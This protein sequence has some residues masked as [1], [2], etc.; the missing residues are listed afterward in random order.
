MI[1]ALAPGGLISVGDICR[2]ED[3]P[4]HFAY[5]ILKK[6]EIAGLVEAFRGTNGGYQL[7]RDTDHFTLYDIVSAVDNELA[8]NE[9]M[10]AGQACPHNS[11]GKVCTVHGELCRIQGI[12]AQ[13]L[14]EKRVSELI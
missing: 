4:L 6:L 5:K 10:K 12:V 3:I 7:V 14:Q 13:A 9:C 11:A 2:A 8:L 1:R